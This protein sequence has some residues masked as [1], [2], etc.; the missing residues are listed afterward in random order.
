MAAEQEFKFAV[1]SLPAVREAL[2]GLGAS[3]KV[4][5]TL[6]RNWVLDDA[7]DSLRLKGCL[8]R[9][10]QWGES[11][12]LTYKGPARFSAGLKV[13]EELEVGLSASEKAL[14][15][16]AALGFSPVFYYEKQRETWSLG[17]VEVA[18]DHTPMGDFVELE[19]EGPELRQV[20]A[21]LGFAPEAALRG[22]Y[23]ELWRSYREHH[24]EAP[25]HMVF[26]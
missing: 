20:A 5:A 16:L 3:L 10:R 25:E 24:P 14:A 21:A 1:T 9:V 7:Q 22:T 26:S 2:R 4:E 19:G 15:I 8:L 12:L 23:L 17:R 18:L 13:R 11:H 6:E